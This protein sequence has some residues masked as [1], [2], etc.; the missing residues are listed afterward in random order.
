[1]DGVEAVV[2]AAGGFLKG[3]TIDGIVR[4]GLV[5]TSSTNA[6]CGCGRT[7]RLLTKR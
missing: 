6:D 3:A 7:G 4:E 1:M 2:M 5:A